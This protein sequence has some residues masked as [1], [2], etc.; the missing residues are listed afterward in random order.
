MYALRYCSTVWFICS[1]C[2][3][4]CEWNAV[5]HLCLIPNCAIIICQNFKVYVG[6]LSEITTSGMPCVAT[7]FLLR[8]VAQSHRHLQVATLILTCE[9]VLPRTPPQSRRPSTAPSYTQDCQRRL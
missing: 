2:P 7:I 1:I 9:A 8:F 6:P 5:E 3:S 4:V